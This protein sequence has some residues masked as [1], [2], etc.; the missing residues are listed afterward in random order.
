MDAQWGRPSS[1]QALG[2]APSPS[3]PPLYKMIAA[4]TPWEKTRF[5]L[6]SDP[7]LPRQP[8]GTHR[9]FRDTP[10]QGYPLQDSIGNCF[11]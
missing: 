4:K 9:L 5:M 1:H 3:S 2:T 10:T 6:T 7:T 8:V 11:I